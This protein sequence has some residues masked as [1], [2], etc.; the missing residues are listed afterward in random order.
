[1]KVTSSQLGLV[2][3][4]VLAAVAVPLWQQSRIN[5]LEARAGQ[6]AT[7]AAEAERLA[8][9]VRELRARAGDRAEFDRLRAAETELK[10]EVARLR[11]AVTE[12]RRANPDQ[13]PATPAD[14]TPPDDQPAPMA[15][16]IKGM[17]KGAIEQQLFGQLARMK[18]KLNLSPEQEEAVRA[19]FN[20]QVEQAVGA[21]EKMF[22]GGMSR[23]DLKQMQGASGNPEEDIKALLTPE[24]LE[25]YQDYKREE[26]V[27]NARLVANAELLQMQNTLGLTSEQ[28]D[29]VFNALYDHTL[30]QLSG[31]LPESVRNSQ[32]PAAAM[33]AMIEQK[34]KALEGVL[35]PEQLE[36]FR[37]MQEQQANMIRGLLPAHEPPARPAP[38]P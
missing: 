4:L 2:A 35:T 10:A 19:V 25:L 32:D 17:M 33:D 13:A 11:A 7:R 18:T 27:A 21:A 8:A 20:R 24:Q 16:G 36:G 31:Q 12:A 29:Q 26:S 15:S 14:A 23:E 28:Q 5:R 9:E 6:E 38:Q 30:S 3:V 22:A 37:R 34:V 1:M